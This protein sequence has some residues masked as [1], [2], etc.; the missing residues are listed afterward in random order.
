MKITKSARIPNQ[1]RLDAA[2][3]AA[4]AFTA[5]RRNNPR[6]SKQVIRTAKITFE[7]K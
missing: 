5:I 4:V 6:K 1:D 7:V 3:V 2:Q